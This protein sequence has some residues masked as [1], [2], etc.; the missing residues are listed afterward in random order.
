MKKK[1]IVQYKAEEL[2]K[3]TKTDWQ[4]LDAMADE[5]IDTSDI[6]ELDEEW[7]KTAKVILPPKKKAISLRVDLE[8]LEWFK[9]KAKGRGYQT[10]MNAVLEAYVKAQKDQQLKNLAQ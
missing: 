1:N 5:D 4:R 8:V 10:L 6:P 2:P 7:F 3:T 9:S